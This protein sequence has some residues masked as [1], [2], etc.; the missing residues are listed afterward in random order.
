M[1]EAEAAKWL[2][3]NAGALQDKFSVEVDANLRP[4]YGNG[5]AGVRIGNLVTSY[6]SNYVDLIG[7]LVSLGAM[8]QFG[9]KVADWH[10]H[11]NGSF[12]A[13]WGVDRDSHKSAYRTYVSSM[14]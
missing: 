3:D 5:V 13:S 10:T 9:N 2:N 8:E 12:Y 6:H 11:S 1:T 7:S 14:G 4:I